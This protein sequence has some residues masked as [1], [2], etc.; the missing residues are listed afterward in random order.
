[1]RLLRGVIEGMAG[2]EAS[3]GISRAVRALRGTRVGRFLRRQ[4]EAEAMALAAKEALRGELNLPDHEYVRIS[5]TEKMRFC[6]EGCPLH[7]PSAKE[8][9]ITG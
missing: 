2:E 4:A 9:K 3:S 5:E 6:P 8:T 7:P 1:M